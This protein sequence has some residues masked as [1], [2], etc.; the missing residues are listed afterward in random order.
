[1]YFDFHLLLD[2]SFVFFNNLDHSSL[3]VSNGS[4][5][6]T[7]NWFIISQHFPLFFKIQSLYG[8]RYMRIFNNQVYHTVNIKAL[9]LLY[10][11]VSI[12]R[13]GEIYRIFVCLIHYYQKKQHC[14][15]G[16]VI[17]WWTQHSLLEFGIIMTSV[18]RFW[19]GKARLLSI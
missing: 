1:M 15:Q 2:L 12:I 9:A 7:L 6:S 16:P 17:K 4:K 19:L 10:I 13:P 5:E 14:Y 11:T 18:K 8:Q 3:K